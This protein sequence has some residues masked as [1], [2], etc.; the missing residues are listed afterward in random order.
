MVNKVVYTVYKLR[1][2]KRYTNYFFKVLNNTN[3]KLK[4]ILYFESIIIWK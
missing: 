2:K 3:H 4:Q 1:I